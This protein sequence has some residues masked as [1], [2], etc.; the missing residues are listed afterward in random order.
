MGGEGLD[1]NGTRCCAAVAIIYPFV[2]L[3]L[4]ISWIDKGV[5]VEVKEINSE[6]R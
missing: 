2:A 4:C 6:G 1:I 3:S 5:M